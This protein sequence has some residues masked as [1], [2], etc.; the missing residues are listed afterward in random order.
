MCKLTYTI[1]LVCSINLLNAQITVSNNLRL[2]GAV[3]LN[4]DGDF[5][6]SGGTI[7]FD[8]DDPEIHISGAPTSFGT[9][10]NTQGVIVLDGSSS[11]TLSE[12]ETFWK[13]KINNSNGVSLGA[14]TTINGVLTLGNGNLTTSGNTLLLKSSTASG[15][16][17]GHIVGQTSLETATNSDEYQIDVGNGTTWHPIKIQLVNSP[18]QAITY[19]AIYNPDGP[20]GID[21]NTYPAGQAI[22]ANTGLAHVNNTYYYDITCNP[23]ELPTYISLPLTGLNPALPPAE[24]CLAHFNST[25]NKWE[26]IPAVNVPSSMTDFVKGIATSFSPFGQGSDGGALPVDLDYFNIICQDNEAILEW[27]TWSE[28]NNDFFQIERSQDL[29][30]YDIIGYVDG[31]GSTSSPNE[32]N[33]VDQSILPSKYYYYRL[34]QVDYDLGY[35]HYGPKVLIP[36]DMDANLKAYVSS[37]NLIEGILN[38]PYEGI[39]KIKVLDINGKCINKQQDFEMI[40]GENQ[41]QINDIPHISPG[42]YTIQA[43]INQF[44]ESQKLFIK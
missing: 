23:I 3:F 43:S 29:L 19:T 34:K 8:S 37:S 41:F 13:L 1:F 44:I 33:F 38:S 17:A 20:N 9:L 21:W 6:A 10:D 18:G 40:R 2:T 39:A 30:E 27:R 12:A 15:S 25:S 11:Q 31:N 22:D 36:C 35:K 42:V 4:V 32:Y 26:K 24:V 28:V 16:D 14:N 7:D 5:D